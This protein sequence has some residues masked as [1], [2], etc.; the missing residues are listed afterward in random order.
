MHI[1][2][3]YVLKLSCVVYFG[4]ISLKLVMLQVY[5]ASMSK[6]GMKVCILQTTVES[7]YKS[8][9]S[10]YQDINVSNRRL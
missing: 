5:A 9:Q 10:C 8:F 4:L 1:F 2:I 3:L 6:R 7:H